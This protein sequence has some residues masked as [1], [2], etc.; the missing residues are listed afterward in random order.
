MQSVAGVLALTLAVALVGQRTLARLN[1]PG[2]IVVTQWG[3]VDFRDAVYYPARAVLEGVNPYDTREYRLTYPVG[4]I[5]P[6]YA[7]FTPYLYVPLALLPYQAAELVYAALAVALTLVLSRQC[8]SYAGLSPH[9]GSVCLFAALILVSRPG[10]LNFV[11]GQMGLQSAILSLAALH[12]ARTRPLLAGVCLALACYKPTFGAPLALLMLLRRDFRAVVVGVVLGGALCAAGATTLAVTTGGWRQLWDVLPANVQALENDPLASPLLG[13]MR[14]DALAGVA[15]LMGREPADGMAT[16]V[17]VA[18]LGA[19]AWALCRLGNSSKAVGA[20]GLS[21]AI[22]ALSV[23]TAVYHLFYDALLLAGPVTAIL[24]G[25][26][27]EWR[28]LSRLTRLA[29]AGL[30][31]VPFCNLLLTNAGVARLARGSLSWTAVT[32]VNSVALVA[33]LVWCCLLSARGECPP[34]KTAT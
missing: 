6:V 5:F 23:V 24:A 25:R 20:D 31:L 18:V 3:L 16:L 15:R 28:P 19:A 34:G 30:I 22:I 32:G 7:P 11:L 21:T 13:W 17:S 12:H 33:A 1:V 10:Y 4:N 2:Q 9:F 27:S 14:I 26:R 29:L 8:L